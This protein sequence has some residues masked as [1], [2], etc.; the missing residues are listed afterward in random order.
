MNPNDEKDR[1]G[2][3]LRDL[4]RAR[5]DKYYADRD[6]ELIE[7]MRREKAAG[8]TEKPPADAPGA[9]RKPENPGGA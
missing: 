7:K 2:D 5:E 4:E 3:K 6:K 8:G 1:Y 9:S